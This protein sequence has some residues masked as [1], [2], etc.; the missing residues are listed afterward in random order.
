MR[1]LINVASLFFQEL[2]LDPKF[3]DNTLTC[4]LD[5]LDSES[6]IKVTK[7]DDA[8]IVRLVIYYI[9]IVVIYMPDVVSVSFLLNIFKNTIK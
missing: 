4:C 8:R 2:R 9:H 5:F 6:A 1:N 3:V 7:S